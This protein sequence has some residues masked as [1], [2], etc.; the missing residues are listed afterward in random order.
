V[1]EGTFW[2]GSAILGFSVGGVLITAAAIAVC[3]PWFGLVDLREVVIAGNHHATA[4]EIVSLAHLQR[5]QSLLITSLRRVGTDVL[6][7]HWIKDVSVKRRLPHTLEIRVRER[8]EVGWMSDPSG[9]G[10]LTLGEGGVIVSTDCSPST[11]MIELRGARLLGGGIGAAL[12]DST[13]GR[14]IDALAVGELASLGVRLIDLANPSSVELET[15]SGL[16]VLLGNIN[17][18]L[19]RLDSLT[20]LSRSLDVEDYEVIDLRFGG[21][22]TLVPR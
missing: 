5:G 16:R 15:R 6:Q 2:R 20:A 11:S 14:L 3:L 10:C 17:E 13:V 1:K 4:A 21:E 9:G 18:A 12:A 8:E 22:A 19:L 7:H